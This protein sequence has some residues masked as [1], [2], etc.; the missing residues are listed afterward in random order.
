MGLECSLVLIDLIEPDA[1]GIIGVLDYVKPETAWLIGRRATGILDYSL[2]K[3][4]LVSCLIWMGA[5]ITYID[6]PSHYW[7][8]P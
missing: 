2:D 7:R 3:L 5:T 6:S 1:I 4:V 8:W